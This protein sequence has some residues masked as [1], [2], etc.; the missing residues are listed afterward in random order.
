MLP[1]LLGQVPVG[2]QFCVMGDGPPMVIETWGNF[3]I[4]IG[5]VY[6]VPTCETSQVRVNFPDD[7]SFIAMFFNPVFG[8]LINAYC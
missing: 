3:E 4:F 7:C 1:Q 2:M 6:G 8:G 5:M